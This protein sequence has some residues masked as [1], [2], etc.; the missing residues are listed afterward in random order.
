MDVHPRPVQL[1]SETWEMSRHN[2]VCK[3]IVP[4]RYR[5]ALGQQTD[6]R[7]SLRLQSLCLYNDRINAEGLRTGR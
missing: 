5:L 7:E 2:E 4:F 6:Y 3:K 1:L